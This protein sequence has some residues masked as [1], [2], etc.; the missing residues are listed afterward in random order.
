MHYRIGASG[1]HALNCMILTVKVLAVLIT[2]LTAIGPERVLAQVQARAEVPHATHGFGTVPEGTRIAHDFVIKNSG[3]VELHIHRIVPA[4]GCTVGSAS[5][6]SI[7]PG[8]EGTIHVEFDTTGFRGDKT[9]QIQVVTSDPTQST[10]TLY[11]K[12]RIE[13]ALDLVPE[14]IDFQRISVGSP[15]PSKEISITVRKGSD[16]E[17]SEVRSYS[18]FLHIRELESRAGFRRL[19]VQLMKVPP[20]GE[21]R[22]RVFIEIKGAERHTI[23]VPVR[24]LIIQEISLVPRALSFGLIEEGAGPI[25]RT[26]EVVTQKGILISRIESSSDAITAD[27][28]ES[29]AGSLILSAR[30]D[31]NKIELRKGLRESLTIHA[32]G[33]QP[34]A[35]P[36]YG[37]ASP[38]R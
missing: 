1:G 4:C 38:I 25:V 3:N 26:A 10:V 33:I 18:K 21:F 24:A 11:L 17:I 35:V 15:L 37:A 20:V 2:L 14:V 7:P 5:A 6:K 22:D 12:G 28:K 29:G 31:P 34:L 36:V 8:G 27:I 30:L 13:R 32:E 23:T 9:K 19:S 16:V